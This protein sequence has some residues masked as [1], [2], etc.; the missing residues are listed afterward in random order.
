V[1][2]EE[3]RGNTRGAQVKEEQSGRRQAT[4]NSLWEEKRL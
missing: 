3:R 1:A 2:G 4:D